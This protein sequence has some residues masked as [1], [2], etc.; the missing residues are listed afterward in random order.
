VSAGA[1]LALACGCELRPLEESDA[2]ELHAA[3]ER[4]R[5]QLARWMRWAREQTP[6]QTLDFIRRARADA[7]DGRGFEGAIVAEAGVVGMAGFPAI[8]WCNRSA[9]IGY[10]LDESHRG[11]GV[12]TSAVAALVGHAFDSLRLNRLEIRADVEN[13]ASRAVAERLGFRY[14]G[15]LRQAYWVG[16]RYSDDAVYSLLSGDPASGPQQGIR[17][18]GWSH[19]RAEE[20]EKP[21]RSPR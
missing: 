7:Q 13:A 3:I 16:D 9:Q 21:P 2:A 10:W 8:D 14:E 1:R 17:H 6:E 15:T 5:A 12:M 20:A 11:R 19:G 4:N 18:G